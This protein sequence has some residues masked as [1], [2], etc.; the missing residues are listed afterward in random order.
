MMTRPVAPQAIETRY[1]DCRFR[2][3]TEAR[4]A[5]AFDALGEPWQYELNGY[6]VRDRGSSAPPVRYLP[7]FWLSDRRVWVEVKGSEENLFKQWSQL[8]CAIDP[9]YGLPLDPGEGMQEI[10]GGEV[11]RLLVVGSIPRSK[12]A[13]LTVRSGFL[14]F[15]LLGGCGVVRRCD[16]LGHKTAVLLDFEWTHSV[17]VP[18]GCLDLEGCDVEVIR[19]NE[20]LALEEVQRIN[21]ALNLARSARFEHGEQP[22]V[23]PWR[24]GEPRPW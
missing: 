12:N 11:S 10:P 15:E 13:P 22:D 20:Q 16:L 19:T 21:Y 17:C 24:A 14:L 6:Y 2:S 8:C 3:R 1:A 18:A 23:V 5:V 9:L 7:D 4:W